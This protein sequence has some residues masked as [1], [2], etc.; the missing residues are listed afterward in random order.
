MHWLHKKYA[1][2]IGGFVLE[3]EPTGGVFLGVRER[4]RGGNCT[5]KEV[6]GIVATT[7]VCFHRLSA[8]A[9]PRSPA[10]THVIFPN[11]YSAGSSDSA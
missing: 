1:R 8:V 4:K 10:N 11:L 6:L 9:H 2:E 3:N 5:R 7:V